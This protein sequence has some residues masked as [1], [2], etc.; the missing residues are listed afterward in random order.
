MGDVFDTG[1][2]YIHTYVYMYICTHVHMYICIH[3]YICTHVHMYICT[4]V[5]GKP[6]RKKLDHQTSPRILNHSM[7]QADLITRYRRGS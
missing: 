7:V 4:Y 3:V 6:S 1:F 2:T 5:L